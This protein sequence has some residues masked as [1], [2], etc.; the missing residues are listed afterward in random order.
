MTFEKMGFAV[1]E[2]NFYPTSQQQSV[3]WQKEGVILI[4]QARY[5][6]FNEVQFYHIGKSIDV[7]I[8]FDCHIRSLCHLYGTQGGSYYSI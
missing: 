1:T 7:L 2:Y 3:S 8:G 6:T 5:I 4:D